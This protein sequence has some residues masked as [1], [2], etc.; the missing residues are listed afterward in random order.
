MQIDKFSTSLSRSLEAAL[1]NE[2]TR[3]D[4]R[5]R[6]AGFWAEYGLNSGTY[7]DAGG[8]QARRADTLND[9]SHFFDIHKA[10]SMIDEFDD[11]GPVV[12]AARG[13]PEP[14]SDER[15]KLSLQQCS[16]EQTTV[17]RR[18]AQHANDLYASD[19][20]SSTAA[21]SPLHFFVTGGG[22][23]GKS[24]LIALIVE[25]LRRLRAGARA[26]V[27]LCATTGVAAFNIGGTTAHY[28]LTLPVEKNGRPVYMALGPEKLRDFRALW[29]GVDY[30]II[31]EVSM[32]SSNVLVMMHNRLCEL[33]GLG[34][35]FG[36]KSIICFGDF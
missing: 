3:D 34:S 27:V 7:D 33:T 22:G 5:K 19:S 36:G 12:P 25:H 16:P 13:L 1:Q 9:A 30:V 24:F 21:V 10:E 2:F 31:D 35:P 18:I 20:K 11:G 4:A 26:P 17:F 28:A 29:E 14:M 23:V 15:Y 8:E 32:L 6:G